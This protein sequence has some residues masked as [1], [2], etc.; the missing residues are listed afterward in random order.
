MHAYYPWIVDVTGPGGPAQRAVVARYL[1]SARRLLGELREPYELERIAARV[2]VIWGDRDR[3]V[4]HRGAQRIIDTV[5]ASYTVEGNEVVIGMSAGIALGS[6]NGI[7]ADDASEAMP[8]CQL[9]RLVMF[10]L[11]KPAIPVSEI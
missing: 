4:F 11:S 9:N 10:V 5:S 1:E 2:L 8:F 7:T 3:L 6:T